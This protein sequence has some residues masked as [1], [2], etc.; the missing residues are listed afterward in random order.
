M[1]ENGSF[2]F[3][4]DVL[5]K[6]RNQAKESEISEELIEE[7]LLNWLNGISAPYPKVS[8]FILYTKL[9][10]VPLFLN[11]KDL[12]LFVEWRLKIAK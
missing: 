10:E 4:V 6:L 2:D 5:D 9:K 12:K 7:M 11:D 3:Y 1:G 8:A